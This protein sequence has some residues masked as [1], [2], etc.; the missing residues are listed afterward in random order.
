MSTVIDIR[1]LKVKVYKRS[2]DKA[3]LIFIFGSICM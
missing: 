3:P 2:G 1:R